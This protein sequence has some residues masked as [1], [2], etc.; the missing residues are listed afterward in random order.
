MKAFGRAKR[1]AKEAPAVKDL[2]DLRCAAHAMP[3]PKMR[4]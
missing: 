1:T 2:V 3:M 4:L